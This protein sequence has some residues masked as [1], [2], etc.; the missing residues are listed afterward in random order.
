M[1]EKKKC[2]VQRPLECVRERFSAS[3]A[4]QVVCN[5]FVRLVL[6]IEIDK[7]R[8]EDGDQLDAFMICL[9]AA[10]S[11]PTR[12][13]NTFFLMK[14]IFTFSHNLG[15]ISR[16][17]CRRRRDDFEK[18]FHRKKKKSETTRKCDA[19]YREIFRCRPI[20]FFIEVQTGAPTSSPPPL[21][22]FILKKK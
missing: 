1:N 8:F 10:R 3:V 22:F 4:S 12:K 9:R 6:A 21:H 18:K 7:N 19:N 17:N 2:D 13:I 5:G 11:R 14:F 16:K 20:K 15:E